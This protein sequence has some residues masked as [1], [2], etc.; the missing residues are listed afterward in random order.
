MSKEATYPD[1]GVNCTEVLIL[2]KMK[3]RYSLHVWE[4]YPETAF[5]FDLERMKIIPIPIIGV[6][7]EP[8]NESSATFNIDNVKLI[9]DN[10]RFSID[11]LCQD[12]T[13]LRFEAGKYYV[14]NLA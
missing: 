11:D 13:T 14:E 2:K 9:F 7:F 3:G 8:W 4:G 10:G 12:N 1:R 6:K 5:L